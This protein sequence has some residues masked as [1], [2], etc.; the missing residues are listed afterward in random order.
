ML[1]VMR[2]QIL[3][4]GIALLADAIALLATG[5]LQPVLAPTFF[6][7]FYPA[8]MISSLYGGL[9]PGIFASILAGFAATYFF[10]PPYLTLA[11]STPSSLV[12]LIVLVSVGIMICGLSSRYRRAKQ[13]VEKT[14][15]QLQESQQLFESFSMSVRW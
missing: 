10:V 3:P 12:R 9:G 7:L 13:R 1:N 11:L 5:L 4:Y 6:A 15:H 2:V 8:I 14:A